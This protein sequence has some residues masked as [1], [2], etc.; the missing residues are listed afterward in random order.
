MVTISNLP[1]WLSNT[2]FNVKCTG[3]KTPFNPPDNNCDGWN[4]LIKLNGNIINQSNNFCNKLKENNYFFHFKLPTIMMTSS[5]QESSRSIISLPTHSTQ[6]KSLSTASILCSR[7]H[8][9]LNHKYKLHS[10][11]LTFRNCL[12]LPYLQLAPSPFHFRHAN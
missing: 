3:I 10:P 6:M 5:S 12:T 2:P 7:P 1:S 4:I 9:P 8:L 11:V